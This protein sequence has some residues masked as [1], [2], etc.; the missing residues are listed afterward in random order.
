MDS[1]MPFMYFDPVY[2]IIGLV[3]AG[4]SGLAQAWVMSA[5]N[6]YKRAGNSRNL[7]GAE[8][9][10]YMLEAEGVTDIAIRRYDAGTL[11][12]NFDPRQKVINLSPEVYDGRSISAVGVACHEAGHA[13]Q[14]VQHYAPMKLR[15]M[16]VVPTNLGS[17][18]AI[19][20]IFFGLM[21]GSLG[22]AKLG[23]L[24]FAVTFLF[25]VVTLPVELDAS[26]RSKRALV[27]HGIVNGEEARGVS[28]VLRAA[29]FTYIAAAVGSLIWLLYFMLKTGMLG[30]RSRD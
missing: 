30:G 26:A 19:P 28:A 27:A 3:L 9:A 20:L 7:S 25:Q 23:V 11:N 5:F 8:A 4:V 29:A 6:K 14:Y 18:A 15:S 1:G 21:L 13:L 16:L 2:M 17:R 24:L 10:K 22:L 12:D